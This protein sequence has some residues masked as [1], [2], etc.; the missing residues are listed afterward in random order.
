MENLS[1]LLLV[2]ILLVVT[3]VLIIA[4]IVVIFSITYKVLNK[5]YLFI[6]L[7]FKLNLTTIMVDLLNILCNR[8]LKCHFHQWSDD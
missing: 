8:I 7:L 1:T 6:E 4:K 2:V 5:T 3:A